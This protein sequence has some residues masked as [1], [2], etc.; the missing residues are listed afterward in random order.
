MVR[1][2]TSKVM[3][4]GRAT[5]LAAALVAGL[6][7]LVLFAAVPA[8]ASFP[9]NNGRI[10]FDGN[11]DDPNN[12]DIYVMKADGTEV[13]RLTNS[14]DQERDP[15]FSPDGTRIAYTRDADVWVMNANGT[16]QIRLTNAP[17]A[18]QRPAWSPDGTSIA[19]AS[20][21]DFQNEIY[22]MNAS[23]PEGPTNQPVRLTNNSASDTKPD[24]SPDGTR[25]AFHSDRDEVSAVEIYTMDAVDTDNDGEGDN[26]KRLTTSPGND[27]FAS[28]SP[29]GTRIAFASPRNS[30]ASDTREIH[31]MDAVDT[32]NDGE[33]DDLSRLVAVFGQHPSWSP[34][35]TSIAF[36]GSVTD[37]DIFRVSAD[38]SGTPTNLTN[39]PAPVI[40]LWPS[41][42]PRPSDRTP[43]ETTL[44]ASGPSGTV[45]STSATFTFSSEANAAFDCKLDNGRFELCSSPKTYS[46]LS[47]GQHRFEVRATDTSGNIDAS[48]EVRTWTVDTV[49]PNTSIHTS[50]P[51]F[52]N[53]TSA[54]FSFSAN[55]AASFQC[56]LDP[57]GS[58][59]T[60]EACGSAASA[61]QV[62]SKT[63]SGLTTN[64]SYTFHVKATDQLSH[65]GPTVS[66]TWTVDTA[67]PTGS[68]LINGNRATTTS[69]MVT[70]SLRASDAGSGVPLMRI[71]NRAGALAS[72]PW[73]PF[74]ASKRWR[75][76]GAGSQTKTVFVQY[77]DGAGNVSGVVLDRIRYRK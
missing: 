57:P 50:P 16:N 17:N 47:N 51:N 46:N 38:G 25:I 67:S 44:A 73:Q 18:D 63:Y 12:R 14:S 29:I 52:T 75:L 6:V 76:L 56:R 41:W 59:G 4:A 62:V 48:P 68:V 39:T 31:V 19:F 42:G 40:E 1:G 71:S 24:F 26:L 72:A 54:G 7:A 61:G 22:V 43:P 3:W 13:R 5:V 70:L 27:A 69:L 15:A 45:Q 11:R 32:D 36:R 8:E 30:S 64:G 74:V 60:F 55:E 2:A 21:R 49:G 37:G 20:F 28:Y 34:D 33:G 53:S 23:A 58:T 65:V 77:R 35:G 66:R 10:A 9:G